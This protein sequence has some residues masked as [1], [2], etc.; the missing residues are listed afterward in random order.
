[1]LSGIL[2]W[3][4]DDA[5]RLL[6]VVHYTLQI[7]TRM[8]KM[9]NELEILLAYGGSMWQATGKGLQRR[10]DEPTMVAFNAA[11]AVPDSAS[12]HLAQA[13]AGAYGRNARPASAWHHAI[14]A[15]EASLRKLV[16]PTTR[17][18]RSLTSLMS[19]RPT[20]GSSRSE[21]GR[22]I[23]RSILLSRC[24]SWYGQIRT[25][26]TPQCRNHRPQGKRHAQSSSLRWRSFGGRGTVRSCGSDHLSPARCRSSPAA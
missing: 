6:D 2:A 21:G 22:A 4:N 23:T 9:W 25:V 10:V 12:D 5:E 13:W 1:M 7:P 20:S 8:A 18:R 3:I 11:T 24:L 19:S 26:M 14:K 17:Q 15:L 16:C